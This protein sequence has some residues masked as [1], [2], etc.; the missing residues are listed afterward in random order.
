MSASPPSRPDVSDP[1]ESWA[2]AVPAVTWRWWE[3]ILAGLIGIVIASFVAIP[4][5]SVAREDPTEPVGTVGL[6]IT[7]LYQV[8]WAG[9][10]VAWL[11]LLH[12]GWWRALGWPPLAYRLREATV[13]AG[14]GVLLHVGS[15]VL[16]AVLTSALQAFSDEPIGDAAQVDVATDVFG[17]IVLIGMAVVVAAIVEEFVF[18]GVLFRSI[19]DRYGFWLG[20]AVS[21]I[22]FGLSHS[23]VGD[24]LSIWALRVTLVV[25]GIGLAAIYRARRNLLATMSAHASFNAVGVALLLLFGQG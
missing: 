1:V 15:L 14:L 8:V 3:A 19:A 4:L 21:G 11:A 17:R 12:R 18:R 20:A 13:G 10:L 23:A 25:V 5:F 6:L 22:L 16:Q 7:A 9:T 24:P 2:D